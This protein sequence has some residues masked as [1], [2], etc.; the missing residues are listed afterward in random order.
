[1]HIKD[2]CS[3]IKRS[4]NYMKKNNSIILNIGSGHGTSNKEVITKLRK[5]LKKNKNK[6]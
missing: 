3:A 1:M 2:I 5:V 6:L 4:I